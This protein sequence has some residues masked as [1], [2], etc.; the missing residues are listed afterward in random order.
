LRTDS[1]QVI[2]AFIAIPDVSERHESIVRAPASLVF[3]VAQHFDMQS[4]PIIRAIFQLRALLLRSR[5]SG[6]WR[7][8]R[9]LIAETAAMGW[10]TL[11]HEPG[12]LFIAGAATQPWMADVA[13][14]PVPPGEFAA[15]ATPDMV[16]IVWTI[17]TEALGPELTRFVTETRVA[18]T[19][20]NARRKFR[21]YWRIFGMGILMIRW[22]L[23]PAVRREAER[24]HRR[25]GGR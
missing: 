19:D 16:K 25:T 9:G 13:F 5:T 3:A 22:L 1:K 6:T 2:D 10:G 12:R 17:E 14:T 7:R 20:E 21:R 15:F 24:R 18:A 8:E 4:I 23:V 11:V